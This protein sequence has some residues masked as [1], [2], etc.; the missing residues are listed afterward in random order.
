MFHNYG[1]KLVKKPCVTTDQKIWNRLIRI[2][3]LIPQSSRKFW[4]QGDCGE[5]CKSC[6]GR[7]NFRK[8]Q[9]SKYMIAR[10]YMNKI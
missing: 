4:Q 2:C 9:V 1:D 7:Y 6:Q 5:N 10:K 3:I 8:H